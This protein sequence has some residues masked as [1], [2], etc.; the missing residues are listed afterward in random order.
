MKGFT[1]KRFLGIPAVVVAVSLAVILL[2]S[3]V[4]AVYPFLGFTTVVTVDEPLTIEM[5]WYDYTQGMTLTEYW[6]V[7]GSGD[8]LTL[9]MS[10]AEVQ[11]LA[12]RISNNSYGVLKVNTLFTGWAVDQGYL[13]FDGWPSA[14]SPTGTAVLG[15]DDDPT[16]YEWE[17]DV[18]ITAS[19]DTPPGDHNVMVQF[20]RE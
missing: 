14:A 5:A 12:I 2:A 4:F 10:P 17:G 11:K 1:K 16:T 20:T 3:G 9:S 6:I 19:G 7:D 8:E 15:S 13:T 18:T